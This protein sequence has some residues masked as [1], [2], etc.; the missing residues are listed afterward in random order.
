MTISTSP[1]ADG[2]A[3]RMGALWG[4]SALVALW[5]YALIRPARLWTWEYYHDTPLLNYAAVLMHD[6]GRVPYRD[7]FETTMPGTFLFHYIIVGL[8]LE[9]Q[10]AFVTLGLI[11]MFALAAAGTYTLWRITPKGA[12]LFAPFYLMVMLQFG[13]TALFQREILGLLAITP[14]LILATRPS[15]SYL[16]AQAL[17][18]LLFG[19]ACTI[20]PQFAAGAPVAVLCLAGLT[21]GPFL[22]TA[23]AGIITALTGFAIPLLI[24]FLWLWSY[25][26]LEPFL[27]ILTQYT[28]LYIQL[29]QLHA[30]LTPEDRMQYLKDLWPTFAG[31][32]ILLPGPLMLAMLTF[33][34]RARM[35][36]DHLILLA[37]FS[38]MT[39]IYGLLP[40]LSGQFWDYHY[41]PFIFFAIL[42][43]SALLGVAL[44]SSHPIKMAG[45]AMVALSLF[46]S[47]NPVANLEIRRADA[48]TRVA[49]AKEMEAALH[50]WL[51]KDGRVQPV[52]WAAGALHAMMRARVP[53]ATR[54]FYDFHFA[55]HKSHPVTAALRTEFLAALTTDPPELLLVAHRGKKIHGQDVSYAFPAFEAFRDTRYTRVQNTP[56]FSIYLR[57]DLAS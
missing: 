42:S 38:A 11:A 46:L 54:F 1:S 20:K 30:F 53:I 51:P 44:T 18:G 27:F 5:A 4:Y 6:F 35:A 55:H 31:F 2:S 32:W 10:T 15:P 23:L 43:S 8:G 7:I 36:R 48:I 9:T 26:A 21:Q 28:P 25:D 41:F 50:E 14:A 12:L 22:K 40:I 19:M 17:I 49:L 52:D 29:T 13:P 56:Q 57:G 3:R 24:T 45:L 37:T 33:A 47:L 16:P 39:A 34:T